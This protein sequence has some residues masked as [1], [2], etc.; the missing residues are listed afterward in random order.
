[1]NS[2][3]FLTKNYSACWKFLNETR[4]Y[5][6]FTLAIFA[7]TFLIGFTFP[8]FFRTEIL[9][10]IADMIR[11]LENKT[12]F[13]L[14][15]FIFLNNM[16]A[17][18]AAI[19]LGIGAGILPL[20]SAIVNGY[21]IG[22]VAIEVASTEGIIV[23][24]RLL[25]HGI[26]ELPAIIFSIGIGLKIGRELFSKNI[27]EKLKHNFKEGLRFF[28]FVIFPLLVIAGIIEGILIAAFP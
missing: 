14:I 20:I 26:F 9:Q 2:K 18:F 7:I 25:P 27:K 23:L 3:N 1:M 15:T 8:I 22:F 13:E 21:L 17:S 5:V 6:V 16:K 12:T 11:M 10:F 28:V 24:W 19:V 4:W